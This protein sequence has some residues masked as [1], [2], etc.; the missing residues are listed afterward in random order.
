MSNKKSVC[1]IVIIILSIVI[2]IGPILISGYTTKT[3]DY[4][5]IYEV[6]ADRPVHLEDVDAESADRLQG[7]LDE[8]S[9]YINTPSN[10]RYTSTGTEVLLEYYVDDGEG[11][12]VE[13]ISL[14]V[15]LKT[16]E[17]ARRYLEKEINSKVGYSIN[18]TEIQ[19]VSNMVEYLGYYHDF[20]G[21]QI[22]LVQ[23]GSEIEIGYYCNMYEEWEEKHNK[24]YDKKKIPDF[25]DLSYFFINN[26]MIK[27]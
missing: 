19:M 18:L 14:Y 15:I 4:L 9:K 24:K 12:Y 20:H 16:P 3:I 25:K 22:I 2:L 23:E 11:P 5:N 8:Y 13:F 6:N 21:K 17:E 1:I 10:Y 27:D 26:L 7:I